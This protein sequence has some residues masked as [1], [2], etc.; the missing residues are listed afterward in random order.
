[1][2][3]Q[4]LNNLLLK[5]AFSCMACDGHIDEKEVALIK[6][7]SNEKKIFGDIDIVAQLDSLL[8]EINA[9]GTQFLKNYFNELKAATLSQK[10]ELNIIR[11][12]IDTINSDDI[13]EYSEIKFFK[14]IR[15]NLKLSNDSILEE[16]P[17]IEEYLEQDIISNSYLSRLQDDFFDAHT[18]PTFEPIH[19]LND[20]LLKNLDDQG[21]LN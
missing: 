20:K 6:S 12:A 2:E 18:L 7:L 3:Q 8:N 14:I 11:V 4:T 5:T 1:M 10:D 9:D 17:E 16:L 21:N 19:Q 13:V 15:S